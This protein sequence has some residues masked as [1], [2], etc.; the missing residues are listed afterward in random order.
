MST[1][2]FLN[3]YVLRGFGAYYLILFSGFIFGLVQFRH[4]SSAARGV[5][6][7]IAISLFLELTASYLSIVIDSSAPSQHLINILHP[8]AYAYTFSKYMVNKKLERS[9]LV[10]GILLACY[11]LINMVWVHGLFQSPNASGMAMNVAVVLGSLVTFF[12]MLKRPGQTPLLRQGLFWFNTASLVFY[13]STF[14]SFALNDFFL[15]QYY[16]TGE[17]MPS[18]A[19]N[20]IKGMNYYL[21]GSYLIALWLDSK[22]ATKSLA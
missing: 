6:M 17:Y 3:F 18:W 20:L 15:N 8:L 19:I 11:A 12:N 14:F 22:R 7:I 9:F 2:D 16:S 13:S 10:A 5:W 1:E 21:Y 4:L